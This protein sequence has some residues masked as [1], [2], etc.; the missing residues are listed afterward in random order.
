MKL[1]DRWKQR[2]Q[3]KLL[4][5]YHKTVAQINALEDSF[6]ALS[7]EQ[8]QHKTKEFKERLAEGES[9]DDLKAEGFAT[10]REASRRVLGLRHY[11]VQLIGG[12]VLLEGN[13]AEMATGEGKTLVASL[14][15]YVRALEEKGVHVITVNEYLAK[16]DK[17]LIGQIHSFLG[18]TVSL[19]LPGMTPLEK[20]EA[21][22][23]DI[24]YGIGT[25]FGF[26]FLRDNMAY[27]LSQ[28]V[29]RPYHYAIVDEVDSVLIDEAKTPLIIAGKAKLSENLHQVC[30]K[31]MR[32]FK[33]D[34]HYT[35]DIELKTVNFTEEGIDKIE[36]TFAIDNFYDLEHR[37]L[38]HYMN[39]ALR[40]KILFERDVDYIVEDGEIKL[41]DMNTG[42]IMDG[43]S[44]SEGLHQA[45]EAKE[46]LKVTEEN[47]AQASITIQNY[48]HM[49]PITSG[50]TGTAKTEEEEFRK[51]YGM[52]VVSIPTNKP[53]IRHDKQ[54]LVFKKKEQKYAYL[55]EEI[56]QRHEKGQPILIGTTSIIQSETVAS[57]LDK[58]KLDYHLLNAKSVE[59]EVQLISLAGQKGHIT[60]AT[61]MAG[62]GTDIMLGEGVA[63]LG[64]LHVIGTERH[65]SR[66]ID[67]QLKGR[68]GR[69][70][71]PGSSQFI[72]SLE[73]E[74]IKRYGRDL[75]ERYEK[76]LHA[77][78]NGL[79]LNKKVHELV[80]SIQ[81]IAEGSHAQVREFNFQ[82]EGVI[83]EQRKVVYELRHS[84]QTTDQLKEKMNQ[85]LDEIVTYQLDHFV[86]REALP[87]E[88]DLGSLF[89]WLE[90][91]LL[92]DVAHEQHIEEYEEVVK[93]VHH[94]VAEHKKAV[95]QIK[96]NEEI[97]K[98]VRNGALQIIDRNWG[99]QLEE[100][101]RLKDG[102]GMRS[103]QQEDPVQVYT[104][105]GYQL[106]EWAYAK[107]QQQIYSHFVNVY[108]AFHVNKFKA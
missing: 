48:Y 30:A 60:I 76:G 80:D 51:I 63:E 59:K 88:W 3:S 21:Y 19:N 9:I 89:G 46:G 47:K 10:V 11:D 2:S 72:I 29:Q 7:D 108:N 68:A 14:P 34:V 41:I 95:E 22:E 23:A 56:K 83:N 28:K 78:G 45:L 101:S 61:N 103:Y 71:D 69:Q 73:D 100:M 36:K 4:K 62:R 99:M 70:G 105:E 15:S 6:R 1:L 13:I 65:E 27:S 102:I 31:V 38:N 90:E 97:N 12:L 64:G 91:A 93:T 18:L 98:T 94:L 50:M 81:K 35:Y 75:V 32:A 67:N 86:D 66:R 85:F 49:Y 53:V 44:L 96:V 20:K 87:Q 5:K 24:T 54:D 107:I 25:E 16:R 77:A 84:I 55:V 82:L 26:D 8:L 57:Y 104:R 74:L 92:I 17:E 43:R 106:F 58:A 52:D 37:A 79:I 40:A 33:Q 42:R 39:Q